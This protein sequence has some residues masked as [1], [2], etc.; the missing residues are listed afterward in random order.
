MN[1]YSNYLIISDLDGTLI[2]SQNEISQKNLAAIDYF[3]SRGGRFAIA[4]GRTVQTV[5]PFIKGLNLNGPCILYNGAAV[6]DFH[7]ESILGAEFLKKELLEAYINYCLNTF[8][9]M[10]VEIFT[11]EGMYIVSPE[12]NVDEY[13]MREKQKH[14]RVGL[15]ETLKRDWFKLMLYDKHDTLLEA[16]KVF[17]EFDLQ[18]NF[19]DFFSHEFYFEMLNKGISKG[20]ALQSLRELEHFREKT[21]IAVGDYDNDIEM[22]KFADVGIAVENAREGVKAAADRVTVNNDSDALHDIIHNIIPHL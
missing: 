17:Y 12:N 14:E 22:V 4:T 13:V 15:E 10:V 11:T 5:R 20:S 2:N 19:S 18:K 6:Y 21:I 3:T 8:K 9:N 7:S 16:R 1:E